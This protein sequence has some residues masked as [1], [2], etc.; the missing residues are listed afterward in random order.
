MSE[1]N[2]ICGFDKAW[3]GGCQEAVEKPGDRC[4]KHAG[5]KCCSCGEPATRE[6]DHTGI[7]F[8]CGYPLCDDC[9]HGVPEKGQEGFFLLGG[10]HH[11]IVSA[12]RRSTAP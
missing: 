1:T 2:A 9:E 3:I 7:Q 8:V 10:G 6:C 4:L 5:I 12:I 11:P